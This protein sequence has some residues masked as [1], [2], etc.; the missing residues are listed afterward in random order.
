MAGF[1]DTR[2]IL[3]WLFV[4]TILPIVHAQGPY[5]NLSI[6]PD[7][8]M[9]DFEKYIEKSRIEKVKD[10]YDPFLELWTGGQFNYDEQ[11][12]LSEQLKLILKKR[13]KVGVEVAHFMIV[14]T[15]IKNTTSYVQMDL[16][17]F[18][19]VSK[20]CQEKLNIERFNVFLRNLGLYLE[21]GYAAERKRFRWAIEQPDPELIM[22]DVDQEEKVYNAPVLRFKDT[23]LH[24]LSNRD[25]CK[26]EGTSGDFNLLAQTFIGYGGKTSW[27]KVGLAADS[28]F[29]DL[30]EFK[31]NLNSGA[32]EADSA[33][34]TY[35]GL[36]KN[37]IKGKFEDRNL[38]YKDSSKA[39][40]PYFKSYGGGVVIENLIP[41]V[42]YE[43][44][45]SLKGIRKIGSSYDT[46][47]DA[48]EEEVEDTY[49]DEFS[50]DFYEG[51]DS[52]EFYADEESSENFDE[53][54]GWEEEE[55]GFEAEGDELWDE[56]WEEEADAHAGK[57]MQHVKASLM[58]KREDSVV[59]S[60]AGEA[61]ML[62]KDN[63]FGNT[64]EAAI[65]AA[66]DS[67]YHPGMD[68]IYNP[69]NQTVTLKKP[70]KGSFASIPFTSS[71]HEYFFYFESINWDLRTDEL[72]F[73]AFIDRENKA[74]AIESFDYFTKARF[75][76]FKNV[77]KIN[78]IGALYRHA[79]EIGYDPVTGDP[80]GDV[81]PIFLDNVLESYAQKGY[82]LDNQKIAFSRM[83]PALEGSGFIWIE[84][85]TKEIIPKL[86]L[87][88]WGRAAR[89]KKD[90]DAIQVISK[91]DS[92][93][94]AIM[95]MDSKTIQMNG[96]PFFSLSDSQ[97]VR[98]VPSN[99]K[100][101]VGKKRKLDFS[102]VIAAGKMNFY[103]ASEDSA[104]F[105]F[106]YENFSIRCDSLDSVKFVLVRNAPP[107]YEPT[108]LEKALSST[109]FEGITGTI[110]ID[111]PNNKSGKKEYD[112]YPVFDS[113]SSSYLYW[114]GPDIQGGVYAK[115]KMNFSVEPF[116]LDSLSYFGNSGLSFTG[117]F[118]SSEILPAIKQTLAVMAD[119]SLGFEQEAPPDGYKMYDGKARFYDTVRLDQTGLH[120]NGKMEFNGTTIESDSFTFHFDSVMAD[121]K[122]F[123]LDR[124]FRKGK[125]FPQV[126]AKSGQYKW[127]TKEDKL[128]LSTTDE[129]FDMFEGEGKFTGT[130]TLSD[131]GLIG[132]GS[133]LMGQ[134]EISGDSL[135]FH[136]KDLEAFSARFAILDEEDENLIHFVADSVST[137]YDTWRKEATFTTS[138]IGETLAVFPMHKYRTSLMSGEYSE[139]TK[140]LDLQGVSDY[141]QDN[142]FQAIKPEADSLTFGA[143]ASHYNVSER[144]IEVEGVEFIYVADALIKPEK[145]EVTIDT[146]GVIK[147]LDNAVI[148]ADQ[149]FKY[150]RIYDANVDIFSAYSYS[151]SGKYDYSLVEGK[152]QLIEFNDIHASKSTDTTTIASGDL[153]ED[154]N[155]YIAENILFKGEA[156]LFGDEKYLSFY[157]EVKIEADND[158]FDG[159]WF[160]F[161]QENVNPDSIYIPIP[162][163]IKNENGDLLTV[164]INYVPEASLFYSNFLQAKEDDDDMEILTASGGLTLDRVNNEFKIGSKQK[165]TGKTL[166]GATVSFNDLKNE[167]TSRG[168]F[169]FPYD[170]L[171]NTVNMDMAGT[172]KE[173]IEEGTIQTDMLIGLQMDVLPVEQLTKVAENFGYLTASNKDIDFNLLSFLQDISELLDKNSPGTGYPNTKAFIE[174]VNNAMVYTD[175]KL[176][177]KLPH[178]LLMSGV[179]LKYDE[180]E[181]AFYCDDEV[182][183][184]GLGG[185]AINKMIP[186]KIFY[187]FGD[188]APSG[189]KSPDEVTIYFE[190]DE[191]NWIYFHIQGHVVKT[192]SNYYDDYN[193]PLEELAKDAKITPTTYRFELADEGEVNGFKKM[194]KERYSK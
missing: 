102:G 161:K 97:F 194:F 3:T 30:A 129:P 142:Y 61:F 122:D 118:N 65:Y 83:L 87:F 85:Q 103:S 138:K 4:M 140:E 193:V 28:V 74:S 99:G 115:D 39:N 188:I 80:S 163:T 136:E 167:I 145:L 13:G 42:Q 171:P 22:L 120:G 150:H 133:I 107:D 172:W 100:V 143:R 55:E 88:K 108:P 166:R 52:D 75:S 16:E 78:P 26:I 155:F 48:P 170:F 158:A 45:F 17:S 139:E 71:F 41:N 60:L 187:Q 165:I 8:F 12:N 147:K 149:E 95:D 144:A 96:V 90:F 156:R 182:G 37:P 62:D 111:D 54:A 185:N 32:V 191:V 93:S 168:Y 179:K 76:Q 131:D 169:D 112:H 84:K 121:V 160:P 11:K 40:Y 6:E 86:K 91:V 123:T 38:G 58:I 137:K 152:T 106:D 7:S 190:V 94:H 43:G 141:Q 73:S 119:G 109:V 79:V 89:G 18:L 101:T 134:I 72:H 128:T 92:G 29:C 117:E 53:D 98:V 36:L 50:S 82:N 162:K 159:A 189:E 173:K 57:I 77:M 105:H 181:T 5:H 66:G 44:G 110:Y 178:T 20:Q 31:L 154:D 135:V 180:D 114:S 47:V 49:D 46:W 63:L 33:T 21:N 34:L 104:K 68:L 153:K 51:Y 130:L 67:L 148:E 151:G 24:Y 15:R 2:Y 25:S 186:A 192:F 124:G 64:L 35:A 10:A 184:I 19:A 9:V 113:H 127:Y 132:N 14:A 69:E 116:V 157:G 56:S 59:M 175:I 164:G 1:L 146:N 126:E 177:Q 23:K 176:A 125:Y 174:E 70:R 27:E 183:L 81:V